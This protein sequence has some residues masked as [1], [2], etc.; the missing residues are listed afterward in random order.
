M[1]N[2]VL[3]GTDCVMLSEESAM[4]KYPVEAIGMLAK[5]AAAT[6]PHRSRHGLKEALMKHDRPGPASVRDLIALSIEAAVVH[7]SPA[8][9]FVPTQSGATAWSIARFKLP[10][11][12]V[13]VSSQEATCQRLQFSSGVYPV[14]EPTPPEAWNV[15]A[16][17]WVR[18]HELEGNFA[19]LTEGPSARHPEANNRM[20]IIGLSN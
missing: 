8:A 13:G 11:W 14:C 2:A 3:D 20:E 19:I 7:I 18:S 6:E 1:A 12:I 4:G 5:I 9:L 17:N 10:V 16:K 15:Y